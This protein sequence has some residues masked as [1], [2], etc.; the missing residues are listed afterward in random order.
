[1]I[2]TTHAYARA[3]LVGNPSDGYFGKTIS[4]VIRNFKAT[5][6]LWESPHFEIL[7]THGDLA[8][9]SS[10]GEFLRDIKL[11]GYYGGLRL[12][13][14]TVKRF[15]EF[16]HEHGH[17]LHNRN[18]TLS[19]QSDIPRL[20]GL[21][22]S[23]AIIV[24]TMRALMRFYDVNIPLHL[25]PALILSVEKDELNISAG[26]QDRVI[27]THEGM[28]YMDFD[29]KLIEGRGYGEYIPLKPP[30]MPPL[31]VAYDPERAE[32]SDVP[33][34][35]L[36][37]LYN[38]GDKAVVE[39]MQTYRKLTDRGREALM[40]GDWETLGKVMNDSF[41][42]RRSIM[43]IAPENLRMVEVARASGASAKF[44]GSGGAITGLYRDGKHYQQLSDALAEIRC[45][46]IR[47][48]I[49]DV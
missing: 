9:F 32:V 18:F 33:H 40:G 1:M 36:R 28:V 23:S 35:N 25:Q 4:F 31:Y 19:F 6:Q 29:R 42:L 17:E 16:C 21:S 44:A 34:R 38:R 47:P 12:M 30:K 22:G 15:H 14:A 3:G 8:Q 27:Q 37:D 5:A 11:H 26:L 20:V 49:F 41:D 48:M 39:A 2:I 13:K 45:T 24:A 43:S 46:V 7:P 10:V